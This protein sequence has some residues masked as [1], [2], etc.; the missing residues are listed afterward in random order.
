MTKIEGV[1]SSTSLKTM[2]EEFNEND[3]IFERMIIIIPYRSPDTV[4]QIEAS[5]EKVNLRG[6]G[7][8]NVR[9][10]NTKEFS[11]D[12]RKNRRLDFIGGFEIMD[13]EFRMYIL[14]GLGGFGRG[15]NEFY[16]DN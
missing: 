12:E 10:L 14:E 2:P 8:D 4:K 7:V 16:L 9:Y 1:M 5:Y 15:I 6:L 13:A 11:E 3:A